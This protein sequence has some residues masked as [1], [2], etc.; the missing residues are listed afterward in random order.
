MNTKGLILSGGSGTRL[1]PIT[2]TGAKQL[3]PVAN[4]PILFYGI[5]SMV[6]AGITNIGIVV[7]STAN[8]IKAAVGDGAKFGASITYIQ[9][10]EPLGLAHCVYI[11]REF[12]ADDDFVMYLGDNMLETSI[13]DFYDKIFYA[14]EL[15]S[16]SILVKQ[17][18]NPESFGVVEI[19]DGKPVRLVEKPEVP[20]SDMAMVGVYFFTPDIHE[21]VENI[22]ASSRGELEITDAIQWL[23]DAGKL[24]TCHTLEGW[25]LDTGK[26]DPLLEC[27]RLVLDKIERN[28]YENSLNSFT[29]D[30]RVQ[31]GNSQIFNSRIIGPVA[32][33]DWCVIRN[34][35]IG[36]YTSI[37]NSCIVENTEIQNS[38]LLGNNVIRDVPRMSDSLVGNGARVVRSSGKPAAL[39]LMVSDQSIVEI[40]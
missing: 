34:A 37:G 21:A 14:Q 27:N 1:R 2:Y 8:E 18:P 17:V 33:G 25:W 16:A 20:K 13:N 40:E 24:V 10:E 6:D 19:E 4:K 22:K 5:E 28:I 39:K 31:I 23:I 3:V 26:K 29:A 38:V 11:S 15:P 12:L 36:P 7:G 35:F 32:I 30:G 9:Q